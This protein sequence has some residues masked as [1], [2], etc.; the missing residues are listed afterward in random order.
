M[1]WVLVILMC[2]KCGHHRPW[3][4]TIQAKIFEICHKVSFPIASSVKNPKFFT[5]LCYFLHQ[6]SN[7]A[8]WVIWFTSLK[9]GYSITLSIKYRNYTAWFPRFL[10]IQNLYISQK[11]QYFLD[12]QTHLMPFSFYSPFSS[13]LNHMTFANI[14]TFLS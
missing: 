7:F 5:F 13:E 8:V 2:S 14:R 10:P 1:A 3:L 11:M 6:N 4:Q 9:M 12:Y